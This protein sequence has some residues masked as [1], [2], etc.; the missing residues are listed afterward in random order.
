MID[1]G[2]RGWQMASSLCLV[3]VLLLSSAFAA[4]QQQ[5]LQGCYK[6]NRNAFTSSGG[7][8]VNSIT[9]TFAGTRYTSIGDFRY[10][11]GTHCR[12][13]CHTSLFYSADSQ[14]ADTYTTA[15]PAYCDAPAQGC[16]CTPPAVGTT[17]AYSTGTDPEIGAFVQLTNSGGQSIMLASRG[18]DY[19][20][21]CPATGGDG[22]GSSA[23]VVALIALGSILGAAGVAAAVYCCVYHP[24]EGKMASA[25]SGVV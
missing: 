20:G 1:S 8:T 2:V 21:S 4:A 15:S 5:Q 22:D 25:T 19:P 18:A 12:C 7:G 17:L 24:P 11:D 3:S 9:M 16:S 14:G 23:L 6:L 13:T 10:P